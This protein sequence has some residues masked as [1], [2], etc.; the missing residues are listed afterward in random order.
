MN[1]IDLGE[2]AIFCVSRFKESLNPEYQKYIETLYVSISSENEVICS[3]TPHCLS[4]AEKCLL[5]HVKSQLEFTNW[6]RWYTVEYI[7]E[8]GAVTDG[9]LDG[10]FRLSSTWRGNYRNMVLNLFYYKDP[11]VLIYSCP[12]PFFDKMQKVWDLYRKVKK[13]KSEAE[14]EFI[15]KIISQDEKIIELEKNIEDLKFTNLLLENQ[16]NQYE[17]LLKEIEELAKDRQ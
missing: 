4:N 5:I 14:L 10:G 11:P 17:D 13:I 12:E 8:E 6:Y 9:Q 15:S 2:I 16:K 3:T 7:N 1:Y